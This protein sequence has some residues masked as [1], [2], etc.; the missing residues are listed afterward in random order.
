MRRRNERIGKLSIVFYFLPWNT[1]L[2]S[3]KFSILLLYG[4]QAKAI[5][6]AF[7][8]SQCVN[9]NYN[10]PAFRSTHSQKREESVAS[11]HGCACQVMQKLNNRSSITAITKLEYSSQLYVNWNQWAPLVDWKLVYNEIRQ[12]FGHILVTFHTNIRKGSYVRATCVWPAFLSQ[13]INQLHFH[14]YEYFI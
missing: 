12:H 4:S 14:E 5:R 8:L 3:S 1:L 11:N 2:N 7:A 10:L 6:I 9:L 13:L